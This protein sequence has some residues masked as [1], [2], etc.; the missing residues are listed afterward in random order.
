MATFDETGRQACKVNGFGLVP[1]LDRFATEPMAANFTAWD[2]A[3][4]TSWPGGPERA[5][6]VVC[7]LRRRADR[8]PARLI[9]E[10]A[11]EPRS[12]DRARLG[13]YELLLA[14]EV[15][16]VLE[17]GPRVYGAILHLTDSKQGVPLM[18]TRSATDPGVLV[19]PIEV[20]LADESAAD[21]LA[22]IESGAVALCILPFVVLMRGSG[23]ARN[24]DHWKRLASKP[25]VDL[26]TRAL[27]RSFALEFA[28]LIP[29]QVN[30]QRALEDWEV[31]ESQYSKSLELKGKTQ[32][33]VLGRQEDLVQGLGF[34]FQTPVPEPVRLAIEGTKDLQTLNRWFRTLFEVDSLEEFQSRMKPS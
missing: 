26:E 30:W 31:R 33:V 10:V 9:V 13:I 24:I 17:D 6:D 34:K 14:I 16:G 1:W 20:W 32:G 5:D 11:T 15:R 29:E 4:R 21:T 8:Q 3:R 18:L 7:I 27:F 23:E 2:D 12:D 19:K 25:E 28:E 22:L